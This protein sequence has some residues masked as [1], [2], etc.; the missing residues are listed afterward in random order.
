M[1]VAKLYLV[2]AD[3]AVPDYKRGSS[4]LIYFIIAIAV[5]IVVSA[6]ILRYMVKKKE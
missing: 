2:L 1:N 3:I 5:I 6:I 4:F